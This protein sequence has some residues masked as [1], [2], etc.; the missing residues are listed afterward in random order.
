VSF[1]WRSTPIP[2]VL[3]TTRPALPDERGAFTKILGEGDDAEGAPFRTREIFWSSS[4]RGVFRGMHVPLP[5]HEARKLVFVTE[6]AV[7]DFV[8]DLRTGSPTEGQVW[9]TRLDSSSG[10]LVIP[11]G[12]AHGFE[13]VTEQA[14][15]VYAQEDFHHPES[16]GGVLFSS[17]GI[18]LESA[19]PVVSTRDLAL[20]PLSEF[21]SPFEY[22]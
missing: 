8:L 9:E 14:S 12:C 17:A 5:P 4:R 1:P 18:V 19:S 13:V 10:G 11:E 2:G 7:R 15:M 16:D 3:I 20:P 6:G 22:A 21:D